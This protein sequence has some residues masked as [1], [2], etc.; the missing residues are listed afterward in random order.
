[1]TNGMSNV[2]HMKKIYLI[3]MHSICTSVCLCVCMCVCVCVSK[4]SE[5]PL[6][7]LT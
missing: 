2:T 5:K 4:V 6:I 7:D 3:C 1:M